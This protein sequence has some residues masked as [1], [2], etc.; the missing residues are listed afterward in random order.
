[1]TDDHFFSPPPRARAPPPSPS[2]MPRSKTTPRR[3]APE[4]QA[5][6]TVYEP[7]EAPKTLDMVRRERDEMLRDAVGGAQSALEA[8]RAPATT[9][10]SRTVR[11]SKKPIKIKSLTKRR[12]RSPPVACPKGCVPEATCRKATTKGQRTEAAMLKSLEE[13][14]AA[15]DR[16]PVTV[17]NRTTGAFET[18]DGTVVPDDAPPPEAARAPVPP[19]EAMPLA[20][21][22]YTQARQAADL[23]GAASFVHN[24]ATYVRKA[25]GKGWEREGGAARSPCGRYRDDPAGCNAAPGCSYASGPKKSYC[26][27]RHKADAPPKLAPIAAP[28]AAGRALPS[29]LAVPL[30]G[31]AP[32]PGA[33][34]A[35]GLVP[36]V[37]VSFAGAK[38]IA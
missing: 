21:R 20:L 3:L 31:R 12:R 36:L 28:G 33:P 14:A 15:L 18:L 6:L 32:P 7:I 13:R 10:T 1:M 17:L 27:A 23:A 19:S 16:A 29:A 2:H 5:A 24:G 34:L 37:P 26:T 30:A 38:P 22:Q 11:L 4:Q 9:R 35:T 25:D 8:R